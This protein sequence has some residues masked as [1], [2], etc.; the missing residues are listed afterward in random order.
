M[1]LELADRYRNEDKQEGRYGRRDSEIVLKATKKL[2]EDVG[3]EVR[4]RVEWLLRTTKDVPI[5]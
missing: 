2:S 1:K 4:S 3:S 5:H